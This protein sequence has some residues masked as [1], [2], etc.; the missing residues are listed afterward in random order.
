MSYTTFRNCCFLL[1]LAPQ[2]PPEAIVRYLQGVIEYMTELKSK[3]NRQA[4]V[5]TSNP[6]YFLNQEGPGIWA[7]FTGN[8]NKEAQWQKV[9]QLIGADRMRPVPHHVG[10]GRN[11]HGYFS[12]GKLF[13]MSQTEV[14]QLFLNVVECK[15]LPTVHA[16][17]FALNAILSSRLRA[18]ST[19]DR[20]RKRRTKAEMEAG[21]DSEQPRGKKR[22][23]PLDGYDDSSS[24]EKKRG[25]R[26]G[27]DAVSAQSSPPKVQQRYTVLRG[28]AGKTPV[29]MSPQERHP[30]LSPKERRPVLSPVPAR[31]LKPLTLFQEGI[32]MLCQRFIRDPSAVENVSSFLESLKKELGG[33]ESQYFSIFTGSFP[34]DLLLRTLSLQTAIVLAL[35]QKYH[36]PVQ[37]LTLAGIVKENA[38]WSALQTQDPPVYDQMVGALDHIVKALDN[39][40]VQQ[41]FALFDPVSCSWFLSVHVLSALKSRHDK[42]PVLY[43]AVKAMTQV[44]RALPPLRIPK[45]SPLIRPCFSG[46]SS[47]LRRHLHDE[48]V[49]QAFHRGC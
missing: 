21:L 36:I 27:S 16:H 19:Q 35:R 32:P 3:G 31:Q 14:N 17:F 23:A 43:H 22:G 48:P 25:K 15:A 2:G 18:Q 44:S 1:L 26:G 29:D 49:C 8:S 24:P 37:T 7:V 13:G 30:V 34:L 39:A 45:A 9:C 4:L 33:S 42:N 12:V 11:G 10:S 41:V 38:A 20:K 46:F 5:L 28:G 40:F 47:F 6:T